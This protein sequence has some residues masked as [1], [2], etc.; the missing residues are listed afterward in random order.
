MR[1][2][3]TY[4]AG[5]ARRLFKQDTVYDD[6]E[7]VRLA[8]REHLTVQRP[9]GDRRRIRGSGRL[10]VHDQHRIVAKFERYEQPVI[11]ESVKPEQ[12]ALIRGK[13]I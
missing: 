3:L 7:I 13:L 2:S 9:N 6:R 5:P 4:V 10:Q 12:I 1:Y 11:K 8:R